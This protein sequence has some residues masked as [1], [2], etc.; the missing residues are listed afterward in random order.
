MPRA[1]LL[2]PALAV[3]AL[4]AC[5][6]GRDDDAA[7]APDSAAVQPAQEVYEPPRLTPA[8]SAAAVNKQKAD[9]EAMTRRVMGDDY[10]PPEKPYVDT[11]QKQYESCMRQ[12]GSLEEPARSTILPTCKR[13]LD[14]GRP[15]GR[16]QV[17]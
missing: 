5:D 15:Q 12:A 13:F 17:P 14:P 8:E 3:L 16:P 7:A 2:F 11:P 10:H 1:T 6:R 9:A 4:A